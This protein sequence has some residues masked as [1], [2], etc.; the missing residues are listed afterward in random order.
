MQEASLFDAIMLYLDFGHEPREKAL[1]RAAMKLTRLHM[2]SL[3]PNGKQIARRPNRVSSSSVF[4]SLLFD[5]L[6][7]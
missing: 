1:N 2:F 5:L 6:E 4:C 7:K 3:C